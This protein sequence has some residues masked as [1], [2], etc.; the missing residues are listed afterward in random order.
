MRS[1]APRCVSVGAGEEFCL[2]LMDNGEVVAW[3][4]CYDA[5]LSNSRSVSLGP[6]SQGAVHAASVVFAPG[7]R[8][9]SEIDDDVTLPT[10]LLPAVRPSAP[11][12]LPPAAAAAAVASKEATDISPDQGLL[13][14]V[15]RGWWHGVDDQDVLVTCERLAFNTPSAVLYE[16]RDQW[17][18]AFECHL[19]EILGD[20][21]RVVA[22]AATAGV[23]A[24]AKAD[25]N[26]ATD[27]A[28]TST[29][30]PV[31]K[32]LACAAGE[33]AF[34][35]AWVYRRIAG[36][37]VVDEERRR[38]RGEPADDADTAELKRLIL[39]EL[40]T[41]WRD[42]SLPTVSVA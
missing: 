31:S 16:L 8:V 7:V 40:L 34:R 5:L 27:V 18:Q 19:R 33:A 3:G 2:A 42:G 32:E 9:R 21:R 36:T 14:R 12:S 1:V 41:F 30:T 29:S 17:L 13:C 22:G 10:S 26:A 11:M 23:E 20:L 4:R 15:L 37:F 25:P 35:A 6:G 38:S 28:A 24:A 39:L